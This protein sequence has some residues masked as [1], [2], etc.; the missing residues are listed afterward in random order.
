MFG[1]YKN[2]S[3]VCTITLIN[4]KNL[5]QMK[6]QLNQK[7]ESTEELNKS[8]VHYNHWVIDNKYL[9]LQLISESNYNPKK[10]NKGKYFYKDIKQ[11]DGSALRYVYIAWSK[12]GGYAPYMS[13]KIK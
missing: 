9:R 7:F 12:D 8:V 6:T 5:R 11:D 13:V 1:R 3:Y 2:V 4:N 10:H